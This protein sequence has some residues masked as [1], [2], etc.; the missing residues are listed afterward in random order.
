MTVR[1][2]HDEFIG[3]GN[4]EYHM[5]QVRGFARLRANA[6]TGVRIIT[7]ATSCT[8]CSGVRRVQLT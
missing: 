4:V 1:I 8:E 3:N 6:A 2:F 7:D 5:T